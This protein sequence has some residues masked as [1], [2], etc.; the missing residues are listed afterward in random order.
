MKLLVT[1]ITGKVGSNFMAAFRAA[2]RFS[3]W[4]V[5]AICHNRTLEDD[6]IEVV[7]GS[8]SDWGT[9]HQAM[10]GV[11]HVLHMAAVKEAPDLAIDVGVKKTHAAIFA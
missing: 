11:T 8:L 6:D 2:P 1:G 4:S 7:R 9:V 10:D 3:R 5:R